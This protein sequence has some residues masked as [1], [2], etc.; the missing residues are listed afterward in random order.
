MQIVRDIP[1][2]KTRRTRDLLKRTGTLKPSLISIIFNY[3]WRQTTLLDGPLL[4]CRKR[5]YVI[6]YPSYI[7]FFKGI[8]THRHMLSS[9]CPIIPF[10]CS[11]FHLLLSRNINCISIFFLVI[12]Y[13]YPSSSVLAACFSSS[14]VRQVFEQTTLLCGILSSFPQFAYNPVSTQ[15]L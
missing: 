6:C 5:F 2:D 4:W 11:S 3:N 10:A 15:E 12:L 13:V 8:S 7:V 14:P 1:I 9:S